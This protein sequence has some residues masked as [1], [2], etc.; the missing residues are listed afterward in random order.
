[1]RLAEFNRGILRH[2]WDDR[3][4]ADF[5]RSLDRVNGLAQRAPGFVWMLG[6]AEMERAQLD[7]DSPL[8]AHPRLAS[9]LSVWTD[10]QTLY[11]FAF[12]TVH[13]RFFDR[14]PEWFLPSQ[15]PRLVMW[16]VAEGHRPDVA[17]AAERLSWLEDRGETP[18][19][20]GWTW[21]RGQGA[22]AEPVERLGGQ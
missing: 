9:T 7:A 3:R 13:R 8:D 16:Y 22:L 18:D 6:E 5:V 12:R 10:A 14:G 21:L 17:E 11:D 15:G 19:A 20:F 1:M 2:D 4:V